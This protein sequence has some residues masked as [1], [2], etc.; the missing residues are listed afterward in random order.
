M[1]EFLLI[2][3]NRSEIRVG[4]NRLRIRQLKKT[5]QNTLVSPVFDDKLE[6]RQKRIGEMRHFKIVL[7]SLLLSLSGHVLAQGNQEIPESSFKT[8]VG[9][10]KRTLVDVID[11]RL[12]AETFAIQ[13]KEKIENDIP[14]N[15]RELQNIHE[16]VVERV[17]VTD[18]L[19][20]YVEKYRPNLNK[21]VAMSEDKIKGIM[22]AL[23]IG[24]VLSDN[25]LEAI[26]LYQQNGKLRRIVNEKNPSYQKL[27]NELSKGV[28]TFYKSKNLKAKRAAM[29][30]FE[31]NQFTIM[32]MA[33]KDEDVKFLKDMI[34][35][36]P[37]YQLLLQQT[38]F[39]Q[40]LSNIG[41]FFKKFF[42]AKKIA[43]IVLQKSTSVIV[44]G[45]S[46]GFGNS[47]GQ[48][49]KR[50]GKL[51]Q[52]AEVAAN[53]KSMLRPGDILLEKTP[54]RAT[55]RFIPG[56]WGHNAIWLGTEAE[57]KKLGLWDH[58]SFKP[59]QEKIKNGDA[60]LEALRPGVT[61]NT[62]EH[63]LDIDDMAVL[64][65]KNISEEELKA[66]LIRTASQYGKK[67][68][69]N[70]DV[71][72]QHQLVC[73]ELM[74]MA[75]VDIPWRT[76]KTL[77]RHTINPDAIA[78]QAIKGGP[79]EVLLFYIDGRLMVNDLTKKMEKI[80]AEPDMDVSTIE[81]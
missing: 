66:T 29:H 41:I 52:S 61:L 25:Y 28:K 53:I 31:D 54:F 33:K 70:F 23:S 49:Q 78:E 42:G 27:S 17:A 36:S 8:D 73:S 3:H 43:P 21:S 57:V 26:Q 71:E 34:E 72:T 24:L 38:N 51:Y 68:D 74:F 30:F 56:F 59:I 58:P 46:K 40:M 69:F 64:R 20:S 45:L 77:G 11:F 48:I 2:G 44:G 65:I 47:V 55:D 50:N 15:G 10:V 76:E 67:Y 4:H 62:V 18:F 9:V 6:N 13:L 79:F 22:L 35:S 80:L 14:V 5:E 32:E 12:K 7:A 75:Y 39:E 19:M 1:L 37:T 60:I 16:S 63:F 81:P